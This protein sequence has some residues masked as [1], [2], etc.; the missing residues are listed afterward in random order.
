MEFLPFWLLIIMEFLAFEL[1]VIEFVI[2]PTV[3][4]VICQFSDC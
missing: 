1:L 4:Y 3:S 2:V